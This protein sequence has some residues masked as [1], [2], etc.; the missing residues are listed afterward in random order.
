[1]NIFYDLKD[2]PKALQAGVLA[3]GNF[4]GVHK[5]HQEVIKRLCEVK[6]GRPAGVLTFSPHPEEF[7]NPQKNLFRLSS[8][9]Q[10]AEQLLA[11]G[12]DFVILHQLSQ[13]F[14]ALSA[15]EFINF[16]LRDKLQCQELV[17]G[18][19]F[20]FGAHAL[21]NIG[22]LTQASRDNFFK[23]HVVGAKAHKDERFSSSAIRKY[24]S[25]GDLTSAYNLLGRN[26]SLRGTVST[27]QGVAHKLGYP[28]ANIIPP[29]NFSLARGVYVSSTRIC[30]R[31]YPSATNVGIRPSV[32][33][34][35]VLMIETHILGHK[36]DLVGQ[37]LEIFFIKHI[38]DEI[39]FESLEALKSQI[40]K[41]ISYI[42]SNY[43]V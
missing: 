30:G 41:D 1:M 15:Q 7:L 8:D 11:L 13:E 5:G 40:T 20:R 38:R 4:D 34:N 32:S 14:L 3:I 33:N 35:P 42:S 16:I 29:A 2:V 24:L 23:L 39:K 12:A 27:G 37:E 26:F 9:A 6:L 18:D 43:F 17:V 22:D 10:K 25:V 31:D 21:G 28:T 36:L 19:D